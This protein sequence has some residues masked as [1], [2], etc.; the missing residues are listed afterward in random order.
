MAS[1]DNKRKAYDFID[2]RFPPAGTQPIPAIK[3]RC[4][5]SRS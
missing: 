3:S 4:R 5:R 1:P 2:S